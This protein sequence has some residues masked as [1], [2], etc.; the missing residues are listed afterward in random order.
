MNM[1]END[2]EEK[3]EPVENTE[4]ENKTE[5]EKKQEENKKRIAEEAENI[6]NETKDTV[7]KVKDTIMNTDFKKDANETTNFV[8]E[9]FFNPV[10]AVKRVA[11]DEN[12]LGK[13]IILM[14]IFIVASGCR[15]IVS[16]IR[17]G[18]LASIGGN[19]LRFV[20]SVIRPVI[21]IAVTSIIILIFNK[22]NKKSLV[23]V[24]STV[25]VAYI[26]RIINAVIY[27]IDVLI[28]KIT[29]VT[30]PIETA[31]AAVSTVLLFCGIKFLSG[32]EDNSE[33][34]KKYAIILF[35]SQLIF[36]I[37]SEIGIY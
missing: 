37:L 36:A 10:E 18:K 8:K 21:T 16:L 2:S 15:E 20:V 26:P 30:Y 28:G 32:K 5:N 29:L 13:I 17:Y 4:E 19:L 23:T 3:K 34:L 31:L 1:E 7:N 12:I 24:I 22:E 9:M 11:E 6:K 27:V 14:I 33:V 35:I 25:V